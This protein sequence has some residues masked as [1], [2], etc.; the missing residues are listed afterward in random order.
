LLAGCFF[1]SACNLAG[2][3]STMPPAAAP[4]PAPSVRPIPPETASSTLDPALV[5]SYARVEA[6]LRARGFLRTDS[7]GTDA[8]FDAA[9]LARN[10][11][12]I[13][14]Y[15]EFD[16]RGG[17]VLARQVASRLHR[18][19]VPVRMSVQVGAGVPLAQ[20]Q[21]DRARVAAFAAQLG[22]AASHPVR[23]TEEAAN[24]HVLIVTES[25]RRELGPTLARLAPGVSPAVISAVTDLPRSTYCLVL[26]I[27]GARSGA[28]ST[29]IAVIRAELPD[30]LRLSCIHEELAQGMGLAN[31]HPGARP[32]IFNDDEESA[33]LT[34]HDELLLRILYDRRLR[35]GMTTEQARPIVIQIAA[36]L[37]GGSS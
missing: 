4:P 23:I 33:L 27:D 37:V 35:P 2:T 9:T 19:D 13:A 6:D 28:Y 20:A 18:W 10:F 31:D 32:S 34:R 29:A 16:T 11:E 22:R 30:L 21:R 24:F 12:R 36:E 26:A 1:L 14:L 7:G 15:S 3:F 8:P 5:A 17:R 25:E